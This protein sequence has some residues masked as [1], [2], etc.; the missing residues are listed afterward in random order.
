MTELG[1]IPEEW[2]VKKVDSLLN[3]KGGYAFQSSKFITENSSESLQVIRMGNVQMANLDVS[4]NPVFIKQEDL[5]ER[6]KEYLLQEGDIL[7]SLTGTVNKRDYGNISFVDVS[8]KYLL[9]QR[10]AC[11]KV[12]NEEYTPKYFY[13]LLQTDM[14]RNQFFEL[15]VGGTGNQ[16]NVSIGDLKNIELV[17]IP[18]KEQE[19]IALILS[20]IDKQ[21]EITDNLIEKTKELKKGLMQRLLTKGIGHSRFKETEIGRI[22]EEWESVKLSDY[23]ELIHGYQFRKEDIVNEGVPIIKIG[24]ISEN[25]KLNL[26][27]L[28]YIQEERFSEF[29]QYK[30]N[31][32][33]VLMALSGATTGKVALV[34]HMNIDVVQNYRVGRLVPIDCK[35][36]KIFLYHLLN[37]ENFYNQL[38]KLCNTSAQPNFGKQDMD[39]INI[40]IPAIEEQKQISLILSSVDEQVEQF[41]SKKAKLKE[42]KKGLMQKLLTGSIR[43]KV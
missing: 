2:E 14:F 6:E 20:S 7:V 28:T 13:Y 24:Q 29:K 39:K 34:E 22:P 27:N 40:I 43:V 16:T 19:K 15:G 31:N 3:I 25:G 41:E 11:F 33:D 30:I 42:L 36:D 4:R 38:M 21:I 37:S 23:V 32:G 8:N 5:S 12:L 17:Y 26:S 18:P 1:E 9:N 35:I 10:V